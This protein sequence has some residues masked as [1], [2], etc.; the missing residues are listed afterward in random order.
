MGK[1]PANWNIWYLLLAVALIVQIILYYL[2]T[3]FWA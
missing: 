2:F 1:Q 3:K